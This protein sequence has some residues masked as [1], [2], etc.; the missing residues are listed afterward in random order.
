MP[1]WT[2]RWGATMGEEPRCTAVVEV[3]GEDYDSL[4]RAARAEAVAFLG[5]DRTYY[6]VIDEARREVEVTSQDGTIRSAGGWV[7]Q[8]RITTPHEPAF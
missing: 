2:A 8:A 4:V 5:T 7:G 6:L 3:R 1:A